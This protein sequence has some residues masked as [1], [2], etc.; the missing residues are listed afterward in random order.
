MG[1]NG[2]LPKL[3][4]SKVRGTVKSQW[5]PIISR[6]QKESGPVKPFKNVTLAMNV[7]TFVM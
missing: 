6:A 2:A 4:P 3:P 1:K 7:E 5:Q